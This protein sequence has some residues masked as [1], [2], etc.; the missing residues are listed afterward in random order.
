[1]IKIANVI[2][3]HM[4]NVFIHFG[5]RL[6]RDARVNLNRLFAKGDNFLQQLLEI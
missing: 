4:F 2:V 1:M 5:V 3:S 6:A